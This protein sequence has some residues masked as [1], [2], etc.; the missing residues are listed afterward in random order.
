MTKYNIKIFCKLTR[1]TTL[2]S[3]KRM[4]T[5]AGAEAEEDQITEMNLDL[6]FI[7]GEVEM[8]RALIGLFGLVVNPVREWASIS[9]I[10]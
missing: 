2:F 6:R 9:V 10:D 1:S 8:K 4:G 3:G 7:K 5:I